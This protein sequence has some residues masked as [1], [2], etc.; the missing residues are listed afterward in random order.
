MGGG[1]LTNSISV[2]MEKLNKIHEIGSD[3]VITEPGV[4][5]H[6]FEKEIL[7]HDLMYPPYTSSKNL[8]TVGGMAANNSAGEK[9]IAVRKSKRFHTRTQSS[10]PRWK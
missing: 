8:C 5:Y 2:S 9:I 1:T 3:F 6:N 4:F 7:K 10:A